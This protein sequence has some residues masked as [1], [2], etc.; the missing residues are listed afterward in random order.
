MSGMKQLMATCWTLLLLSAFLLEPVLC[1]GGRGGSR[2]SSRGSSSRSSSSGTVRGGAGYGG[3]RSRFRAAGRTSPVRVAGAAAAGAVVALT[4]EKWYASAY[5]RSN[6]A[7]SSDEE[8]D[9]YNR[10]NY[11]DALM[12]RSAQNH[13]FLYQVISVVV[14]TFSP[15][16]G[17][18][19]DTVL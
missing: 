9:Y 14:A 1:K 15:K 10:T 3:P 13:C 16:Y 17:L 6:A 5:R 12:S 8:V 19:L 2:G 11:Y 7:D 18:L 4:A